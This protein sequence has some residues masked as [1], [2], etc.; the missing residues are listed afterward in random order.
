M[1]INSVSRINYPEEHMKSMKKVQVSE[2][3]D[4]AVFTVAK[5]PSTETLSAVES[6]EI[7]KRNI[8]QSTESGDINEEMKKLKIDKNDKV[9]EKS[10]IQDPIKWFG[11]LVSPALRQSQTS[12]QKAVELSCEVSS[13]QA[14]YVKLQEQYRK[15]KSD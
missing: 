4:S 11:V 10:S 9:T 6:T 12:F 3:D 1:G 5:V 7:R 2:D 13:L 14:K 15:M 8:K